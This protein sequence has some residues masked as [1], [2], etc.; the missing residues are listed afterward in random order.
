M[1]I[2]LKQWLSGFDLSSTQQPA[3]VQENRLRSKDLDDVA[4]RLAAAADINQVLP[5][6]LEDIEATLRERLIIP[7]CANLFLLLRNQRIGNSAVHS[8]PQG[9][10]SSALLRRLREV[11]QSDSPVVPDSLSFTDNFDSNLLLCRSL[12]DDERCRAWLVIS[13]PSTGASTRRLSWQIYDVEMAL[14]KGLVAWHEQEGRIVAAVEQERSAYAAELHDS[15]AQV[16][17]YLQLKANQLNK[18]CDV[19]SLK[20]LKPLTEDLAT[21][22]SCA[23]QQTRELIQSSRLSVH[24]TTLLTGIQNAIKDFEHQSAIVFELDNR[25]PNLLF[26]E[27]QTT[28]LLHIVR[29]SLSNIVRHS[30]ASH[31]R[32][33]LVQ[34][35]ALALY[36]IIE[37][38]GCGI[39]PSAARPDSFGLAIM[40][41]RAEKIGAQLT[42]TSRPQGG[43]LIELILEKNDG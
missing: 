8:S 15:L 14:T 19:D 4:F 25:V 32:I 41:E 33:R 6:I 1:A 40:K 3:T 9:K 24:A 35:T 38:N 37:D 34:T 39:Q 23:Y 11:L 28:Q 36:L 42:V 12:L 22:T 7:S 27:Q 20:M 13:L 16:L 5:L 31:A 29:E 17:G 21:Y 10:P 26:A 18:R 2:K 30:H 43:T